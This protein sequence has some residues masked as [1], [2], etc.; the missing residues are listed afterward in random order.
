MVSLFTNI[1]VND[2]M[3][4]IRRRFRFQKSTYKLMELCMTTTYFMFNNES[5]EQTD[6]V[7]M[8]TSLS[9]IVAEIFMD[10]VET[11]IL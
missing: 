10:E 3:D 1:P 6:G 9:P 11:R 7:A 4:I 5:Y 8:G 2:T